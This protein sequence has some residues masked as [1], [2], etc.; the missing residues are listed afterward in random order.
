MY[1]S[2]IGNFVELQHASIGSHT[3]VSHFSYVGDAAL[4][5]NVNI[6]AGPIFANYNSTTKEK[7]KSHLKDGVSIGS[8][9]VIVASV[10]LGENVCV[11]AGSVITKNLKKN[12][13]AL[14]RSAQKEYPNWVEKQKNLLN[15]KG[16]E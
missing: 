6:G 9:A 2:K 7:K 14:E 4:G 16:E 8:N 3:N 10:E 11:G 13:L 5:S 1:Y 15:K 12:S